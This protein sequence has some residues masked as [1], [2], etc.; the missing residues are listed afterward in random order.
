MQSGADLKPIVCI[1]DEVYQR[2]KTEFDAADDLQ[3]ISVQ[4]D[5]AQIARAIEENQACAAVLASDKY[6]D[7]LYTSLPQGGLIARYGVGHD[8]VDKA[9]ATE[10]NLFVTITPDTLDNSVAEHALFLMG[11]LARKFST[12]D[13]AGAGN[14]WK[15]STGMELFESTL[16]VIGCGNIGRKVAQIASAGFGMNVLGYDTAGLDA[17]NMFS[18]YGVQMCLSI[19]E[20]LKQAHFISL[21]LPATDATRDFVNAGFLSMLKEDCVIINTSRGSILDENALYDKV[22]EGRL[23]AGLDVYKT[24]PYAPQDSLKDLRSLPNIVMSPHISSST[25][26]AS[27]RMAES[28]IKNIR[29]CLARDY[30]NMDIVNRDIMKNL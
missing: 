10:N 2:S 1:V 11:F 14:P 21:H 24:E 9:K 27:K 12:S 26:N 23:Y 5:E 7:R 3:F 22:S 16:F 20:G 15:L 17:G 8:C 18:Q 4:G 25:R 6:E 19:E 28:V 13:M 30:A 29:A